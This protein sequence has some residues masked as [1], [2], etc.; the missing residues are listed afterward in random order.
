MCAYAAGC[1]LHLDGKKGTLRA[2]KG[3]IMIHSLLNIGT[4]GGAD[5]PTAVFVTMGDWENILEALNIMGKGMLGI[6]VVIGLIAIIMALLTK[7][8]NNK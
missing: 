2:V 6:F 7:L 3:E 8:G 4:I 1:M 5:G